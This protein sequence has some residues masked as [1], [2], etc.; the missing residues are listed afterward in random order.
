V[1]EIGFRQVKAN[2]KIGTSLDKN[3]PNFWILARGLKEFCAQ[4]GGLLPL[5]GTLPD[6]TATT[7]KFV[8][9]QKCFSKLTTLAQ[10]LDLPI[11]R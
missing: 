4:N 5:P 10:Y 6:M 2:S 8:Q 3:S 7:E 9:L 11:I 1:S